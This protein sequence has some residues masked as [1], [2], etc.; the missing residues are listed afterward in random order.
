[1]K[2]S[3]EA[4]LL[5]WHVRAEKSFTSTAEN[6]AQ[7]P[8]QFDLRFG[9]WLLIHRRNRSSYMSQISHECFPQEHTGES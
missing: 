1:M 3:V 4:M 6:I 8:Q 7:K 5:Q 9:Q 2:H